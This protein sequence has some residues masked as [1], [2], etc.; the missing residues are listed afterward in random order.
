MLSVVI[1]ITIGM[2]SATQSVWVMNFLQ[3]TETNSVQIKNILENHRIGKEMEV[4]II[5][6]GQGDAWVNASNSAQCYASLPLVLLF[7]QAF[8]SLG[9]VIWPS[10]ASKSFKPVI[11]MEKMKTKQQLFQLKYHGHHYTNHCHQDNWAPF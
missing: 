1:F 9:S 5:H 7:L 6:D 3:I 8:F 2:R 10:V 11:G 4:I